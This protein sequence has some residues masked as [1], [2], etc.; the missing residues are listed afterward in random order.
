[1]EQ[2]DFSNPLIDTELALRK[3][4]GELGYTIII[5]TFIAII[6][7][8]ALPL[9]SSLEDKN[10]SWSAIIMSDRYINL[11]VILCIPLFIGL[12]AGIILIKSSVKNIAQSFYKE[13]EILLQMEIENEKNNSTK[14]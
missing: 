8:G 11:I 2:L 4:Q 5:I 1:M 10:T 14:K 6:I 3:K 9:L 12:T 7:I 13:L